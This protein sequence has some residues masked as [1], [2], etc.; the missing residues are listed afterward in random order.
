MPEPRGL[1]APGREPHLRDCRDRDDPDGDQDDAGR[2]DDDAAGG[3]K[4]CNKAISPFV[5]GGAA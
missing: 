3:R 1:H 2:S 5:L 4:P